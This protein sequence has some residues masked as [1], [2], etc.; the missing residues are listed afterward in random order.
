MIFIECLLIIIQK[1][2]KLSSR[3]M[4]FLIDVILEQR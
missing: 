1:M 3:K 4:I 2:K